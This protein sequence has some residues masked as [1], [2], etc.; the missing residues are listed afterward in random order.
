MRGVFKLFEV[1]LLTFSLTP[2]NRCS[3]KC[4]LYKLSISPNA[5]K[6]KLEITK[7]FCGT[8]E[9]CSRSNR[10]V[11]TK[12]MCTQRAKSHV[13]VCGKHCSRNVDV[14]KSRRKKNQIS[15]DRTIQQ[16]ALLRLN[17]WTW[18]KWAHGKQRP[19][20]EKWKSTDE[21]YVLSQTNV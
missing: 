5:W 14:Q 8:V 15:N 6:D 3:V 18:N 19:G 20:K 2:P 10:W 9:F 21:L 13:V 1:S 17:S 7:N 16:S 11:L 4:G 12:V